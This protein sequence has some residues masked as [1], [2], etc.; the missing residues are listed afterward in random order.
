MIT[1]MLTVVFESLHGDMQSAVAQV[2]SG[3]KLIKNYMPESVSAM[4]ARLDD[5]GE[6][7]EIIQFFDRL[8][9]DCVVTYE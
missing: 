1:C 9:N 7:H 8:D 5:S 3:L 6:T 4:K 2:R